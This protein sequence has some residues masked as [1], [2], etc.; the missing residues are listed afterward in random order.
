MNIFDDDKISVSPI[1]IARDKIENLTDRPNQ[2]QAFGGDGITSLELKKA[3]DKIGIYVA[4]RLKNLTETL[5]SVDAGSSI[6]IAGWNGEATTI[7]KMLGELKANTGVSNIGTGIQ[8]GGENANLQQVIDNLYHLIRSYELDDIFNIKKV[9][10]YDKATGECETVDNIL[11]N[12]TELNEFVKKVQDFLELNL[13]DTESLRIVN[14]EKDVSDLINAKDSPNGLASLDGKGK[15][16][17]NIDA[18]KIVSGTLPLSCIPDAA[19]ERTFEVY[20]D[21]ERF[22]L[23]VEKVQNGDIVIVA[24]KTGLKDKPDVWYKVIDD[25]K[26]NQKEGYREIIGGTTAKATMA[27][28]FEADYFGANS[29]F[30]NFE[31]VKGQGWNGESIASI[32]NLL[33]LKLDVVLSGC[34]LEKA[35]FSKNS[36]YGDFPF[37][38]TILNLGFTSNHIANVIFRDMSYGVK[39]EI[40]KGKIDV[41]LTE[42]PMVDL[43]VDKII[44]TYVGQ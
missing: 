22:A 12:L 18:S 26:L 2:S 42:K 32:K 7:K 27:R 3:F 36:K 11:R 1:I 19:F 14:I 35:S 44:L 33:D 43:N 13:E 6:G 29:I 25:T 23:T 24:T 20:S 5:K 15:I 30:E 38:T 39:T 41:Y 28:E 10:D 9:L 31:R 40:S 8:I 21:E 16:K 34:V 4:T 17:N 37:K